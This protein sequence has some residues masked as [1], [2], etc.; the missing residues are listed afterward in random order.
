MCDL[1]GDS[2]TVTSVQWADK[3]DLLAV[4]TNKGITQVGVLTVEDEERLPES[5]FE[6]IRRTSNY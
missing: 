4:G 5:E 1:A 2:D 3:G 6:K